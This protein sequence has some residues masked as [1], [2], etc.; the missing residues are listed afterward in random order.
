MLNHARYRAPSL[1]R[2]GGVDLAL[3][4]ALRAHALHDSGRAGVDLDQ[5]SQ[6]RAFDVLDGVPGDLLERR[7][8]GHDPLFAVHDDGALRTRPENGRYQLIPLAGFLT[9]GDVPE[10]SDVELVVPVGDGAEAHFGQKAAAVQ[11]HEPSLVDEIGGAE[12]FGDSLD[13]ER[14]AKFAEYLPPKLVA[15]RAETAARM[16]IV[17]YQQSLAVDE[18]AKATATPCKPGTECPRLSVLT[19]TQTVSIRSNPTSDT[20][21]PFSEE[22]GIM[23]VTSGT[24]RKLPGALVKELGH[25]T[26]TQERGHHNPLFGTGDRRVD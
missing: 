12:S 7:V 18:P 5:H 6:V 11:R 20:A 16:F 14:C 15:G 17:G 24:V 22:E 9:G 26:R 19:V 23:N 4:R 1:R 8:H 2:A 13:G 3:P 10:D 25:K 21:P